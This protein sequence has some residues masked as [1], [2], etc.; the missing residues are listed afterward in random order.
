LTQ[1]QKGSPDYEP[2]VSCPQCIGE[3]SEAQRQRFRERKRQVDL[4]DARGERHLGQ[5]LDSG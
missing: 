2:A 1:A 3:Y 4:A 5:R